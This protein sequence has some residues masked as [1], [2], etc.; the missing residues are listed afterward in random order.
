[1]NTTQELIEKL[2][3]AMG[4]PD[5]FEGGVF[6]A[7]GYHQHKGVCGER[8]GVLAGLTAGK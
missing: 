7:E 1:M 2:E 6:P 5:S 4:Q 3:N 8:D